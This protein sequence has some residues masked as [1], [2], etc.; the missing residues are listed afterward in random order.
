MR[1]ALCIALFSVPS[2]VGAQTYRAG[3]DCAP[4]PAYQAPADIQ[5]S[6]DDLRPV[7]ATPNPLAKEFEHVKIGLNIPTNNY[8]N[9]DKLNADLSRS[10]LELGNIGVNTKTGETTLNGQNLATTP[11]YPADCGLSGKSIYSTKE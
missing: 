4:Q 7:E 8:V 2:L 11:H 1:W 3:S 5:A 6:A 9:K 10:D